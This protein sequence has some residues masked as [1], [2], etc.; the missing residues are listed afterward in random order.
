M[1][2]IT[3]CTIRKR[4]SLASTLNRT[5]TPRLSNMYSKSLWSLLQTRPIHLP[6]DMSLKYSNMSQV[7]CQLETLKSSGSMKFYSTCGSQDKHYL[8]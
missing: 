2:S 3:A 4:K 5:T 6:L 8:S 1:E 7:I